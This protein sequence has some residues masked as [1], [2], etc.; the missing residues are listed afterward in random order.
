MTIGLPFAPESP[1]Y[2]VRQ[3]RLDEAR[4]TLTSLYGSEEEVN[5]KLA[6]IEQ[7]VHEDRL[8]K[9]SRWIDCFR[10]T[11]RIRTFISIGGFACQ[12]FAGIIFVLG[13]STYFFQLAGLDTSKSFDLGVG[14]TACGLAGN[15]LSWVVVNSYGRRKVFVQGMFV[16]TT[17]LLLIGIL[18]VIP[19]GAAK[20][21]QAACTVI[22]AFVYFLTIGA[23][24]FVIL[25]ETSSP[26]LR[27]KTVGLAS[28]T[29]ATFGI[30]MNFTIPYMVD[31]D[32]ANLKGKVGFV[33]GGLCLIASIAS[34]FFCP[35]LKGR[36]FNEI[37][38]MFEA[39]V[40]P[41][42]MGE[43]VI[44]DRVHATEG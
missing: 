14:V 10:G 5:I 41:R 30:I 12:H 7:T 18:D 37:N 16:L 36:T 9:E 19:T 31:P 8:A 42:K 1:W 22:Y 11:N 44:D 32:E 43:Y 15:L 17:L 13:Y 35:E 29:Q 33:F 38:T 26:T 24:A 39:R 27:A 4:A 40:P 25:G 23:M 2:L 34:Y 28:A 6:A 3:D 20:W 21:V